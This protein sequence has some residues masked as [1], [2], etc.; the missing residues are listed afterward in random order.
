M[1]K[2]KDILIIIFLASLIISIGAIWYFEAANINQIIVNLRDSSAE[3]K[4]TALTAQQS[5]KEFNAQQE[6]LNN[7]LDAKHTQDAI[8]LALRLGKPVTETVLA[9][10]ATMANV[11]GLVSDIRTGMLPELQTQV[12]GI[13]GSV[14]ALSD[15]TGATINEVHDTVQTV[16]DDLKSPKFLIAAQAISDTAQNVADISKLGKEKLPDTIDNLNKETVELTLLTHN[17]AVF[18]GYA[19]Q[20]IKPTGFWKSL[21]I[22]A[23]KSILGEGGTIAVTA[24][25]R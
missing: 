15:S 8:G 18:M 24:I 20:D 21:L 4:A 13:G 12:H 6:R 1:S 5:L 10:R 7:T 2:V 16:N 19:A 22:A 11:N 9:T 23:G 17:S 25:K 14:K 3:V